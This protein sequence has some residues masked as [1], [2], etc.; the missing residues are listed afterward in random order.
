MWI[1]TATN[2][3]HLPS[4]VG[5]S[6]YQAAHRELRALLNEWDP[7]GVASEVEDEYDSLIPYLY[8]RLQRGAREQQLLAFLTE[9]LV[10]R[11]GLEPRPEADRRVA[12]ELVSWWDERRGAA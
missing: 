7:I 9:E 5:L 8:K 3:H 1:S 10:E 6:E 2:G 12:A 4:D 11:F